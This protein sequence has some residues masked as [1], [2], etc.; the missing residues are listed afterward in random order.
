MLENFFNQSL[1]GVDFPPQLEFLDL[2]KGFNRSLEDTT[3][4]FTLKTLRVNDI[5]IF[6]DRPGVPF[7]HFHSK[8][9]IVTVREFGF[10]VKL[11]S[12]EKL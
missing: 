4:P 11:Y 9:S 1:I 3:F 12:R 7:S 6:F 10:G 5:N 8:W 2:G